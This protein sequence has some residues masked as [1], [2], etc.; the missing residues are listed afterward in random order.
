MQVTINHG[1]T[2]PFVRTNSIFNDSWGKLREVSLTY[3]LPKDL[4]QR[5]KVFQ[6]LSVSI[7][8]RDLFYLFTTLPDKINPESI[9]T[10]EMFRA[11]NL[12]VYREYVPLVCPSRRVFNII[13]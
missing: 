6:T 8:G 9:V 12:A 3:V 2:F 10:V 7:I 4:V 1:I 13:F 11:Y 5:T